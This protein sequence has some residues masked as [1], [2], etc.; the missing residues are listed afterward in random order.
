[1]NSRGR[2]REGEA[3]EVRRMCGRGESKKTG[4]GNNEILAKENEMGDMQ[5]R[6]LGLLFLVGMV[7]R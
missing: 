2:D 5:I 4:K 6:N 3:E 1:M 7:R